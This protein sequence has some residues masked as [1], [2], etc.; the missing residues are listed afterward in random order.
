MACGYQHPQLNMAKKVEKC[1]HVIIRTWLC[2]EC[3]WGSGFLLNMVWTD[4]TLAR[5]SKPNLQ[6]KVGACDQEQGHKERGYQ[7]DTKDVKYT[8]VEN[9]WDYDYWSV[10]Q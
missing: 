5:S 2:G 8:W 6:K 3:S 7:F 1:I 4:H 10:D 9:T